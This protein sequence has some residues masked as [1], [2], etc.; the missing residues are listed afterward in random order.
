MLSDD[1][2]FNFYK[3]FKEDPT[4]LCEFYPL[5]FGTVIC[6]PNGECVDVGDPGVH[7]KNVI[8]KLGKKFD[9]TRSD[10]N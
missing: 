3:S 4:I 5:L 8:L 2:S 9:K 1:F 7:P 10:L 6:F